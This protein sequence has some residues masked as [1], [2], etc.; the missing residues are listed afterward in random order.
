MELEGYENFEMVGSGGN[1]H[2]YR[3]TAVSTG[4]VVAV[5]VLRGGGDES[6]NRRFERE[7][8]LM[9][10]LETITNVVPIH[11]SG[12]DGNGD[13]YLVMPLYTG[14][15]LQDR[16]NDGPM[17]W[18][19][20]IVLTRTITESIA[21]AHAKRILH[22]DIKPANVLLDEDEVPWLADFGISEMMGHTASMSAQMITPAFT[23]P[24]RLDGAKPS[25]HTDLYGI[26]ATLFALLTGHEPYVTEGMTGPMAV[27]VAIARD[28][29]P[30]DQLP[31]DI[32]QSVRN[33]LARGMAKDPAQRP[34]SAIELL[35]LLGD[36]AEGRDVAAPIPSAAIDTEEAET[37]SAATELAPVAAVSVGGE[38]EVADQPLAAVVAGLDAGETESSAAVAVGAAPM[39]HV[40]AQDDKDEPSR[41]KVLLLSALALLLLIG[42]G[43]VAAFGL[44]GGDDDPDQVASSGTTSEVESG[45]PEELSEAD[46]EISATSVVA[47]DAAEVLGV[48]VE[49]EEPTNEL[50][51]EDIDVIDVGL[52]SD[53][54]DTTDDDDEVE[55]TTT[56][57]TEAQDTTTT[58]TS[59]ST[60][61][62]TTTTTTTA[63]DPVRPTASFGASSTAV[64]EGSTVRF[65]D[66]STGEITSWRW[67]FGDGTVSTRPSPSKTFDD[68]GRFTVRLTVAGPGGTDSQL[69]I[70]QVTSNAE[71]PSASFSFSSDTVDVG[72]Q[73]SFASTSTGDVDSVSW[74]MGDG[75]KKTGSSVTHVYSRAGTF[76]VTMT[77]EGGGSDDSVSQEITVKE[78]T[79][80][81]RRRS[82]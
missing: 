10:R 4:D 42:A 35:G 40:I 47:D 41:A 56:T 44:S 29:L 76:T 54:S 21:L 51:E 6:V 1:A 22:L 8:N 57:T 62:T 50:P 58:S 17:P 18:R 79:T 9:G 34:R 82:R 20:A 66:S 11:E 78:A 67:E 16:V 32:P 24:E 74:N 72:E 37:E 38:T 31:E 70:I 71:P 80:L 15:S 25:E 46:V 28:P 33:L 14:G 68:A 63:P 61:T 60:T 36:I 3:A 48:S 13:P 12:F 73:L 23:P 19:E 81:Q 39:S 43:V 7:R 52:A 26:N 65:T 75:T 5:K 77:A 53:E 59:T 55:D 30:I 69:A 64:S 49:S 2:V 45:Q 27:I